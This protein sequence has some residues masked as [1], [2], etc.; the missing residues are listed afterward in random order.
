LTWQQAG[1]VTVLK[2]EMFYTS[3]RNTYK[4]EDISHLLDK[5][6]LHKPS[7]FIAGQALFVWQPNQ[8]MIK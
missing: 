4:N 5:E 2:I 6:M 8:K 7:I 1:Y 3:K